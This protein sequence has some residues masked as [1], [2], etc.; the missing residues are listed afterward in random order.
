MNAIL[1]KREMITPPSGEIP[2]MASHRWP[3]I[4]SPEWRERMRI[5]TEEL[6]RTMDEIKNNFRAIHFGVTR[7]MKE[8]GK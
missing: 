7:I 6:Q 1:D 2:S 8:M 4:G 5:A 3:R